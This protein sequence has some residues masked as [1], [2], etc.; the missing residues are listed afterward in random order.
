MTIFKKTFLNFLTLAIIACSI[1]SSNGTVSQAASH[2]DAKAAHGKGTGGT[3]KTKEEIL[4]D[5]G[6]TKKDLA[7]KKKAADISE[8]LSELIPAGVDDY[9]RQ[10]ASA[11][12]ETVKKN[13]KDFG[14]TIEKYANVKIE[15]PFIIYSAETLGRQEPIYY[16]PISNHGKIVLVL[17]VMEC[18]RSYAA[19]IS[20]DY[21]S[22]L[23]KL[24]YQNNEDYLFY[25][26]GE[27][28]YAENHHATKNLSDMMQTEDDAPSDREETNAE[29]FKGLSTKNKMK[30]IL[31]SYSKENDTAEKNTDEVPEKNISFGARGFSTK[32]GSVVR[33]NTSGCQVRQRWDNTCWAAS[34]ATTV[35]YLKYSKYKSLTARQVCDKMKISY[36]AGGSIYEMHKALK[37]Y[38]ITYKTPDP[39]QISFTTL[40]NNI[41]AQKPVI[42]GGIAKD[43][44]KY[45]FSPKGH[46]V[47]IIG[48]TTYGG[49]NQV[50]F[51]NPGTDKCTSVE[52]KKSGTTFSS[53][54][55]KFKWEQTIR[56]K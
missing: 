52:Y 5:I 39:F 41:L 55:F 10:K 54:N 42:L 11:L 2:M 20:T 9:A 18:G 50:T 28:L 38:G 29:V 12:I 16:Y 48:Y 8:K 19:S 6:L 40:R 34:V 30:A 26:D 22:T 45:G 27:T 25:E 32:K 43:P 37:K 36:Y 14:I 56:S 3:E 17:Y 51:Y 49:I 21:A 44:Y 35:R 47:T 15:K 7:S 1:F 13:P 53:S 46:A 24:D 4:D 31:N 33:L 23:N